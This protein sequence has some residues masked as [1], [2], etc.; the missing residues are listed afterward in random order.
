MKRSGYM[1]DDVDESAS[2]PGFSTFRPTLPQSIEQVHL[3]WQNRAGKQLR[4]SSRQKSKRG[5][6]VGSTGIGKPG[7]VSDP[8]PVE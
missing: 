3:K 7:G 2:F 4:S 5:Y 8:A 1:A 6:C